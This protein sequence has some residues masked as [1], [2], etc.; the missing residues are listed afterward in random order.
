MKYNKLN[1]RQKF[2]YY[3]IISPDHLWKK[4]FDMCVLTCVLFSAV[5]T[6]IK[7]AFK[8]GLDDEDNIYSPDEYIIDFV[9]LLD[10]I[11]SFFTAFYNE[12]D[13]LIMNFKMIALNYLKSW[14]L[15]DLLSILPINLFLDNSHSYMSKLAR[16][17]KISRLYRIVKLSK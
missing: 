14:F 13:I 17:A 6:P 7:L 2:I 10:L 1:Q 4:V 9:F 16:M 11:L 3:L 8:N 12:T 5:F 15:I